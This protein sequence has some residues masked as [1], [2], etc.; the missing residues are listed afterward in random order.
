MWINN[1]H[2]NVSIQQM[3]KKNYLK[4]NSNQCIKSEKWASSIKPRGFPFIHNEIQCI[5]GLWIHNRV[6]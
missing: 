5:N 6:I 2:N 1:M 4:L 3:K